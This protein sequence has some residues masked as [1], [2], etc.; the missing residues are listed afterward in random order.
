MCLANYW[1]DRFE[2]GFNMCRIFFLYY[3]CI[4]LTHPSNWWNWAFYKISTATLT[5]VTLITIFGKYPI[6][7]ANTF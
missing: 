4:V 3:K 7:R 1:G 5:F 6:Q 2:T